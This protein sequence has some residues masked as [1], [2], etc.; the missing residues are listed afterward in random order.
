LPAVLKDPS[1]GEA[2]TLDD[3]TLIGR[4]DGVTLQLANSGVSRQH[5]SI[6]REHHDYWLVDLGSANGS[7]VNGVELTSARVLRNGDRV[8]FGNSLMVF[9]QS[10]AA[11]GGD[12]AESERTVISFEPLA[13]VASE[14]VTLFVADLKGFTRMSELLTADQVASLLREWYADCQSILRHYGA[15]IDKF[16][17]DSVF[18][19]WP[20]TD[21]AT[22]AKALAAAQALRLAEA[23]PQSPTRRALRAEQGISLDPQ[24]G[25]HV[26][27]VAIGQMGKGINTALGDA[28]NVVFR[29]E[30]LTRTT[31]QPVLVSAAFVEGWQ[32]HGVAFGSCGHH[33]VKGIAEPIEVFAPSGV[34]PKE[35]TVR[36][37]R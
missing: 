8:Q 34:A 29:I 13:A 15:T 11:R 20:G 14:E 33:A 10:D 27:T 2:F 37:S 17:G 35:R 12:T 25:I 32:A 26:G 21:P 18:A 16:I 3:F 9:E 5:A 36:L 31:R 6:R 30:A 28:V 1:S 4:G 23:D 19:F 7:Y 24:I 22:R